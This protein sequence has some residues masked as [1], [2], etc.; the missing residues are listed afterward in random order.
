MI[1]NPE[2]LAEAK[3]R[4]RDVEYISGRNPEATAKIAVVQAPETIQRLK[5]L[6]AARH[7][8]AAACSDQVDPP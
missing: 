1:G 6:W 7:R 5:K 4:D 8:G 3:K 2:F